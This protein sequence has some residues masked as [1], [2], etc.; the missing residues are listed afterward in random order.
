MPSAGKHTTG[1]KRGKICNKYQVLENTNVSF[2]WLIVQK[3]F[4]KHKMNSNSKHFFSRWLD[5]PSDKFLPHWNMLTWWLSPSNN[6]LGLLFRPYKT[7]IAV[8]K[9]GPQKK[10]SRRII[11]LR[12]L[13]IQRQFSMKNASHWSGPSRSLLFWYLLRNAS[14]Q[15]LV[16]KTLGGSGGGKGWVKR[17]RM[18]VLAIASPRAWKP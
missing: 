3:L 1:A 15:E 8:S 16:K 7:N 17:T 12:L 18:E 6:S 9:W 10:Q 2:D 13:S 11:V 4:N 5:M 14:W